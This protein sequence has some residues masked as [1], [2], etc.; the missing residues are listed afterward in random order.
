[1]Q[2]SRRLSGHVK[3]KSVSSY[4][5]DKIFSDKRNTELKHKF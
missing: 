1:M 5:R 2:T 4:Q 3:G